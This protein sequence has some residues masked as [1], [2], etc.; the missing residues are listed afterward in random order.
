MKQF[1][2]VALAGMLA[3][4]FGLKPPVHQPVTTTAAAM[5]NTIEDTALSGEW[6]LQPVLP[7]DTAAGILPYIVI[8]ARNNSYTGNNGCNKISGTFNIS[9]SAI[10]FTENNINTGITCPGYNEKE[11]MNSLKMVNNFSIED[12]L[13]L[14]MHNQTVISR[15]LRDHAKANINRI[16]P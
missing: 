3:L 1:S 4:A 8:N 2:I 7:S 10:T 14:L 16:Q 5:D 15:W 9:D 12:S 11:F 13:L 6:F